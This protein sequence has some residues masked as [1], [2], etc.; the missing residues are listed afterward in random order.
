MKHLS[1]PKPPWLSASGLSESQLSWLRKFLQKSPLLKSYH[2]CALEDLERGL[3]NR[4]YL[5]SEAEEGL[6]IGIRFDNANVL[7]PLGTPTDEM[8]SAMVK[9]PERTELHL[10]RR[11]ETLLGDALTRREHT[12]KRIRYY[13][14]N[15]WKVRRDDERCRLVERKQADELR[16]LFATHYPQTVISDWMLEL[17]LVGVWE[18]SQLVAAAGTLAM[19]ATSKLCHIGN[20]LTRPDCRGRG[21][22]RIAGSALLGALSRRGI[23]TFMLGVEDDNEAAW[24]VYEQLGFSRFGMRQLVT[25]EP[26]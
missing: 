14:L 21:L 15:D 4:L 24:R 3:D 10:E 5:T 18:G 22:A 25:L 16:A 2:D 6:V 13:R 20:F 19:S 8:M 1:E 23:E 12:T 17:P 9:L 26:R 11:H 7:S